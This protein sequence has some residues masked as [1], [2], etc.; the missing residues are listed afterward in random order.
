MMDIVQDRIRGIMVGEAVGDALGF[1]VRRKRYPAMVDINGDYGWLPEYGLSGYCWGSR[2]SAHTQ[3]AIRTAND[4]A[5]AGWHGM[6]L[7]DADALALEV[8]RRIHHRPQDYIPVVVLI[9]I[10]Y[11]LMRNARPTKDL[12][13]KHAFK[14]VN[15]MQ[16]LLPECREEVW[17]VKNL[18]KRGLRFC[19]S[20]TSSYSFRENDGVDQSLSNYFISMIGE[21]RTEGMALAIALFSS[22]SFFDRFPLVM[23]TA[24]NHGGDSCAAASMAGCMMGAAMGL[25]GMEKVKPDWI[26]DLTSYPQMLHVADEFW[27]GQTFF[28]DKVIGFH[29]DCPYR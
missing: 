23:I 19:E 28:G 1:P 12:L 8:A 13:I 14:G 5:E 25:E 15:V 29:E 3:F 27:H 9:H 7:S 17:K 24:I 2:I 11:I 20:Y 18:I 16:K 21:E 26:R 22:I 10:I 6:N 4:L